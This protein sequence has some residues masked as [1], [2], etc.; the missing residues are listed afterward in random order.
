MKLFQPGE[1]PSEDYCSLRDRDHCVEWRAYCEALWKRF[2]PY[3][4]STFPG[5]I[6][7]QFHP[8]F[9]EMYLAV[10]FLD[11]GYDLNRRR[12]GGP[13]FGI[14]VGGRR[15]WFEAIAPTEGT[16]ADAVPQLVNDGLVASD[17]PEEQ[18]ILRITGALD[19]K[20]KH[21]A[22]NLKSGRVAEQDGYIV[23]INDRSIREAPFGS[24]VP[25]VMKALYGLGQLGA[26]IDPTTKRPI[27]WRYSRRSTI[28]KASGEGISSQPFTAREC[29]E[30][31]AVLYS[32]VNAANYPSHLG[33]DL[34]V[35]HN[36]QPNV[37]LPRGVLRFAWEVWREDEHVYM[38]DWRKSGPADAEVS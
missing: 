19:T 29:P 37:E 2:E 36:D 5:Q 35:L 7:I 15:Y 22:K 6:R 20:R 23:A 17:P 10:T 13:E 38:T 18:I 3:A 24:H 28:T 8:R 14:D 32:S 1:A 30:V 12:D 34:M 11:L 9:W 27:E 21:W 25:Y 26:A 4:D 31:S 33:G 16:G